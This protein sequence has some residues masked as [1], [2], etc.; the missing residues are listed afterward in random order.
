MHNQTTGIWTTL[1]YLAVIPLIAL[2]IL[3][4]LA[5]GSS[6]GGDTPGLTSSSDAGPFDDFSAAMIDPTKWA[7]LEFVRQVDNGVLQLALARRQVSGNARSRLDFINPAAV[8]AIQADVTVTAVSNTNATPRARVAGYFYD[9]GTPGGG[10]ARVT[11][12]TVHGGNCVAWRVDK[13]TD[14][15]VREEN[16]A[17]LVGGGTDEAPDAGEW[18][19]PF[20]FAVCLRD[21]PMLEYATNPGGAGQACKDKVFPPG[22]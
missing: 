20:A 7:D 5:S 21:A 8:S 6:G 4:I 3:S 13:T 2:G 19:L 15:P 14:K 18:I 16:R 1:R 22:S 9:D 10:F 17:A 11:C 12:V